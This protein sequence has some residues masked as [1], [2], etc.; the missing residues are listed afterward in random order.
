M[1]KLFLAA[2]AVA[3]ATPAAHGAAALSIETRVEQAAR[4]ELRARVELAGLINPS[5]VTELHARGGKPAAC[6]RDIEVE[7]LDTRYITRMRFAAVCTAPP[8][9]R[10]EYIVRGSVQADVVVTTSA[11]IAGQ[12]IT[13]GQLARERRDASSTPGALSSIEAVVG[14]SSRRSLHS[15]QIIDR[16]WLLEPILV[17]RGAGVSIVA[18]NAGIEVQVPGE[19]LDE[20]R[21]DE[22]V[23]VRNTQNAKILRVRVVGEAM[24]EVVDDPVP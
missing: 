10:A 3:A 17:R 8:G 6:P 20:G 19:A 12:A 16:T 9:W 2:V 23:R 15:G 18:R 5:I 4:K 24:V 21:R 1:I 11:V 7:T 13:A 22:I 14:K